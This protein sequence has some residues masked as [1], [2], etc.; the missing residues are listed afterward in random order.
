MSAMGFINRLLGRKQSQLPPFDFSRNRFPAKKSWPPNLRS[1]TEKQQ[2]SFERKFKRRT[3][4]KA[5]KPT[6]NKWV[7][8][9]QW[10]VISFIV[11]HGI[12]F[13]DF[14]KDPMNPTP[15]KQP[16]QGL[17]DK[18]W[19]ILGNF[20]TQSPS[21]IGMPDRGARREEPMASPRA[22]V[23]EFE[24]TDTKSR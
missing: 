9:V 6:W 11:V 21:T 15:G 7:K 24:G 19:A 4:L 23:E 8:I 20:Y 17:R 18:M 14:S 10:S 12:F 5:L 1:L 16:F 3:Q 22:G 13:Y 2:Y